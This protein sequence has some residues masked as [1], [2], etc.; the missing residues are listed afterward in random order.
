M[1]DMGLTEA[2]LRR[3]NTRKVWSIVL[4]EN[5][6]QLI[7]QI[8]VTVTSGGN[9]ITWAS[10][11]FSLISVIVTILSN[12][13]QKAIYVSMGHVV[14]S[15]DV[16]GKVVADKAKACRTLSDDLRISFC[17][18]FGLDKKSIEFVKHAF[19]SNGL[20]VKMMVYGKDETLKQ[21]DF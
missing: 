13:I 6:P 10:I 4:F 16:T 12:T 5:L 19:I 2:E 18:L 20:S 8:I 14:V 7:L 11:A 21:I 3:F 15:F 17:S 1:G 9:F